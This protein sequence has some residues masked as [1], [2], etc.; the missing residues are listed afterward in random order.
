MSSIPF[1]KMHGCGNDFVILD[2]RR[3]SC[4]LSPEL[5]AR[6]A[7]RHRG[8]GFDQ[9]VLLE[10]A[11][12]AAARLRF[13]NADGS[14]SGA[15]GNGT[16]CAARLL[17]DRGEGRELL[18]RTAAGAIPC[19]VAGD[20]RVTVRLPPPRFGWEEIPLAAPCDT[21]ALPLELAGLPP[22]VAVNMGNPHAV[23]FVEDL[24]ALD[25]EALGRSIE[26]HPLFPERVNVGFAQLRGG[27][28]IRLRVFERGSGLTLACGSGACA[29]LVAAVRRGLV[30]Q[31]ARLILDGGVLEISWP[32][33][34]P[35]EMAG[36]A[37]YCFRGTFE[38]TDLLSD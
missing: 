25:V 15:C 32:G 23:F 28:E 29:A 16:R 27:G 9:L 4:A 8:I 20:G 1:V 19:R 7:D 2:G 18:L 21:L 24:E 11:G 17:A 36:P 10:P 38:P 26:R 30:E 33:E 22:P 12:D 37:A 35:V 6:M 3:E 14:E 5:I 13:F 34:G 31:S